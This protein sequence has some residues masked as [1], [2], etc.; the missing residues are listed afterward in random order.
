MNELISLVFSGKSFGGM[1][2]SGSGVIGL[3]SSGIGFNQSGLV[4]ILGRYAVLVSS[5]FEI[6]IASG[7]GTSSTGCSE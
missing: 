7:I 3:S 2:Q 5:E 1:T 6:F 4:L